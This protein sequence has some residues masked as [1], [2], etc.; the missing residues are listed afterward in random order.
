MTRTLQ[1]RID[2]ARDAV[3]HPGRLEGEQP[4]AFFVDAIVSD[5]GADDWCAC[6]TLSRVGRYTHQIS[7]AGFVYVMR[8]TD[9]EEA[10]AVLDDCDEDEIEDED[11]LLDDDR[12]APDIQARQA[13]QARAMFD[14]AT[15][16][17]PITLSPALYDRLRPEQRARYR[18]G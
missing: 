7:D 12:G 1:D 4:I 14:S 11:T 15:P 18:R 3:A 6:G 10:Q 13:A 17:N 9:A 2:E 8:H 16:E 5:S